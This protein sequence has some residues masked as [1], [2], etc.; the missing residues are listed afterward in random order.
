MV[1]IT[2][3]PAHGILVLTVNSES[4]ARVLFLRKA[5]KDMFV[6]VKNRDWIMICKPTSVNGRLS[7]PFRKGFV[8]RK[9]I[10]LVKMSKF[11]VCAHYSLLTSSNNWTR[12]AMQQLSL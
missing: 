1:L 10:S 3:M 11:T 4:F 2:D 6:I 7:L 8:F 12:E 9:L 5:L